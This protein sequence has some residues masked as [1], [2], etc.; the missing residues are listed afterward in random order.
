MEGLGAEYCKV[1]EYL[2][3]GEQASGSRGRRMERGRGRV[4]HR[5]RRLGLACRLCL[6]HGQARISN[7]LE[8]EQR[9]RTP[10]LLVEHGIRRAMMSFCKVMAR[11]SASLVRSHGALGRAQPECPSYGANRA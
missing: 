7:H 6:A 5:R 4:C 1:M 8:N 3:A 11:H 10:E 9:F 2:P